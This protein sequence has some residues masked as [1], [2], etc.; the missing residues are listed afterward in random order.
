MG[1]IYY[2]MGKSSSGKDTVYKK[3]KEQYPDLRS[4]VPYT[5]RPIREGEQ[6]GVEYYFVDEEK[7]HEMEEKSQVIEAR[8]YHTRC[9]VWTYFTA[10]DGQIDLNGSDYLLIG[11]LVSYQALRKYFGEKALVP[12]YLE[13]EDGLRLARALE[14]ERRQDQPKYAEMCRRFLAD[15]KDFSEENLVES[16][17]TRRFYNESLPECLDEIGAYIKEMR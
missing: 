6:N 11:T 5:T 3:L 12:V 16:G 8:S 10:D 14:R 2:V 13:V 4:V 9:G 1:K 17:I 15:E 7:L